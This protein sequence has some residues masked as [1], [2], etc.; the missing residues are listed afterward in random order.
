MAGIL[1]KIKGMFAGAK[2]KATAEGGGL[3][4]LKDKA[5]DIK[6]KVDDLVDKAGDKVPDQVKD[7]YDKVSDKVEDIIPGDSD[8]D[9]K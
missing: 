6:D 2:D 4:A 8:G 5:G 3:D 1:D 7:G 9:G